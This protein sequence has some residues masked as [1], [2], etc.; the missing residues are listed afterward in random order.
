M[1]TDRMRVQLA[2]ISIG[3]PNFAVSHVAGVP[4]SQFQPTSATV[5]RGA[6]SHDSSPLLGRVDHHSSISIVVGEDHLLR[7]VCPVL[8]D[9]LPAKAIEV[10]AD[11]VD[12]RP[13]NEPAS[14]RPIERAPGAL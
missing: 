8:H 6:F 14:L 12:L 4:E 1:T 2:S 10:S 7:P 9:I 5:C 3:I 13:E 11:R